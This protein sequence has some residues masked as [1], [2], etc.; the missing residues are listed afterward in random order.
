MSPKKSRDLPEPVNVRLPQ[1]LLA[2]LRAEAEKAERSL[3]QEIRWRLLRSVS[4]PEP[5]RVTETGAD[6]AR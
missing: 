1:E 2:V 5:T 3:S 6:D 4:R